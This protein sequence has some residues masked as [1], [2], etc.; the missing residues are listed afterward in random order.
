M[1]PSTETDVDA[2]EGRVVFGDGGGRDHGGK[3]RRRCDDNAAALAFRQILRIAHGLF[4]I[5]Q[6]LVGRLQELAAGA[7]QFDAAGGAVEQ[8]Q[9]Q[10]A[11]QFA[12]AERQRRLGHLQPVRGPGEAAKFGDGL[13]RLKLT[14]RDIH[15]VSISIDN[16]MSSCS[17]NAAGRHWGRRGGKS[18]VEAHFTHGSHAGPGSPDAVGRPAHAPVRGPEARLGQGLVRRRS[19]CCRTASSWSSS[20]AIIRAAGLP[21]SIRLEAENMPGVVAVL[22][23]AALGPLGHAGVNRVL[24]DMRAAALCRAGGRRGQRGRPADRGGGCDKCRLAAIDAASLV[25]TGY[26]SAAALAGRRADLSPHTGRRAMSMRLSHRLRMW[27]ASP[28]GMSA[29]RRLRSSRARRWRSGTKR[30]IC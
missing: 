7:G 27:R 12:D 23:A 5:G 8:A 9:I 1:R 20:A 3:E 11:L 13:E 6:Q 30:K 2:G 22:T 10:F 24:P 16:I 17:M 29:W 18:A 4:Q 21:A 15:N 14:Q 28:S 25:G 26:R 19:E